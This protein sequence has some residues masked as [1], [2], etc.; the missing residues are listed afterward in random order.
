MGICTVK[1]HKS[2][3]RYILLCVWKHNW[4]LTPTCSSSHYMFGKSHGA[5]DHHWQE[6]TEGQWSKREWSPRL[7]PLSHALQGGLKQPLWKG[8]S[9]YFPQSMTML[10]SW[11][12]S[13]WSSQLSADLLCP[14]AAAPAT[15]N[16]Q[17]PT[18]LSPG[19]PLHL[20]AWVSP[21]LYCPLRH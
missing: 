2:F 13:A 12:F 17:F 18:G 20:S 7:A 15:I 5:L 16:S 10:L 14:G 4:N 19:N 21:A 8:T 9:L 11:C 6:S 1:N 3:A